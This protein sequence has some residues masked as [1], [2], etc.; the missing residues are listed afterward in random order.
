MVAINHSLIRA[1][2]GHFGDGG[3]PGAIV[4]GG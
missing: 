1:V 3:I 2:R 4:V